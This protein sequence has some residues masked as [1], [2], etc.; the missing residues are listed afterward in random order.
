MKTKTLI[1]QTGKFKFIQKSKKA[2][3]LGILSLTAFLICIFVNFKCDMNY[4]DCFILDSGCIKNAKNRSRDLEL[5]QNILTYGPS[6][7]PPSSSSSSTSSTAN[8]PTS[9]DIVGSYSFLGLTKPTSTRYE[10]G[11]S[12]GNSGCPSGYSNPKCRYEVNNYCNSSYINTY[13]NDVSLPN[14]TSGSFKID[15]T[16]PTTNCSAANWALTS[17]SYR[18][19]FCNKN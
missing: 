1:N 10:V 8:E 7:N 3:I 9:K 14:S 11:V 15:F 13:F 12:V 2:S 18:R 4:T 17:G 5:L 19:C 16:G 6:I